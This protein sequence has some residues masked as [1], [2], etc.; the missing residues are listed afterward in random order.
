M[1][2]SL[3]SDYKSDFHSVGVER[4]SK[5]KGDQ[6][7]WPYCI[8]NGV[9]RGLAMRGA[10]GT[11]RHGELL[12]KDSCGI[13]HAFPVIANHRYPIPEDTYTLIR[14]G[15]E[16]YYWEEQRVQWVVGRR[17]SDERFEKLSVFKMAGDVAD[18]MEDCLS[19]EERVNILV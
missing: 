15:F 2:T 11:D 19:L 3:P 14:N 1:I 9:V 8:E 4:D 7:E 18:G 17:L 13:Q 5:T 16:Y 6:C 12:V 10:P